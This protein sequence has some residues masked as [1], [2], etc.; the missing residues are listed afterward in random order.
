LTYLAV[1][2]DGSRLLQIG[3]PEGRAEIRDLRTGRQVLTDPA[4]QRGQR[5]FSPDGRFLMAA[6]PTRASLWDTA[7]GLRSAEIVQPHGRS[8]GFAGGGKLVVAITQDRHLNVFA[9]P[10]G[11]H[12]GPPWQVEGFPWAVD[13]GQDGNRVLAN[14]NDGEATVGERGQTLCEFHLPLLTGSDLRFTSSI[15]AD[16]RK[17][18]TRSAEGLAQISDAGSCQWLTQPL[19]QPLPSQVRSASFSPDG[20]R[21]LTL[22]NQD[23]ARVWDLPDTGAADS[24]LLADLAEAVGGFEVD[25]AGNLVPLRNQVARLAVLRAHAARPDHEPSLALKVVRWFFAEPSAL[26]LSPLSAVKALAGP[27]ATVAATQPLSLDRR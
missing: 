26:T 12:V 3:G 8:F 6:G 5:T 10:D 24:G 14:L 20:E 13:T 11:R 23:V 2:P 17:L 19:W 4:I 21:V 18:L 25:R 9:L 7:T 22:D 1:S 16:G 27:A 15:S